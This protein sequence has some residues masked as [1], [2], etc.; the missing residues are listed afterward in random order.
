MKIRGSLKSSRR[1]MMINQD[2]DILQIQKM[3]HFVKIKHSFTYMCINVF[4]LGKRFP[5]T[6][7]FTNSNLRKFISNTLDSF[8]KF[9]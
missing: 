9:C 7:F 6:I 3:L 8:G 5:L 1:L 4:L 2:L